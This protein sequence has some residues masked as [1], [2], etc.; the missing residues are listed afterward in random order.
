MKQ[1][2]DR[3]RSAKNKAPRVNMEKRLRIESRIYEF[4]G[5]KG[6]R[7]VDFQLEY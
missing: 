2:Q 1:A 4:L 5:V 3:G 6:F 7:V